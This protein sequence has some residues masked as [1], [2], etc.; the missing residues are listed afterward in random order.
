MKPF[1]SV[2]WSMT[3]PD[4]E[5]LNWFLDRNPDESHYKP[6]YDA[7]RETKRIND[8][9]ARPERSLKKDSRCDMAYVDIGVL[10]TNIT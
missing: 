5:S 4:L 3:E 1:F 2:S 10:K 6:P 7:E 9:V 8:I